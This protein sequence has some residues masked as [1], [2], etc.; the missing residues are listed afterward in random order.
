MTIDSSFELLLVPS[1]WE[2][3][4]EIG[5]LISVQHWSCNLFIQHQSLLFKPASRSS[6]AGMSTII[7]PFS[8]ISFARLLGLLALILG[9]L[10]LT[11]AQDANE[12]STDTAASS[13]QTALTKVVQIFFIEERAY[14]GLPYTMFHRDSGSVIGIDADHTTYVITTTRSD[15]RPKP[16]QSQTDNITSGLPTLKASRKYEHTWG[17]A[18]GQPSTITQG[19]ATFMFTGTRFGPDHTL[20]VAPSQ[21]SRQTH[22]NHGPP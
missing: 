18:T 2:Q 21:I 14:E 22:T 13:T 3:I 11:Q 17:N 1:P 4:G 15:Q 12:T 9:S 10:T 5:Y 7:S 6:L 8:S 20:Y 16:T 19:P